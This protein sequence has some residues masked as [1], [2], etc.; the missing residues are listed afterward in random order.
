MRPFSGHH[1]VKGEILTSE[2]T[3]NVL[4]MNK[5]EKSPGWSIRIPFTLYFVTSDPTS[6]TIPA[7]SLPGV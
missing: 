4:H 7:P 1:T 5:L 6:F 3:Q 2:I